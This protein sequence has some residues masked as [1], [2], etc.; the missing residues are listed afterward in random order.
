MPHQRK[1]LRHKLH[2]LDREYAVYKDESQTV[3]IFFPRGLFRKWRFKRFLKHRLEISQPII[4]ILLT[5]NQY[6]RRPE[7]TIYFVATTGGCCSE[8]CGA[9]NPESAE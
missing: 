7:G 9:E 6:Q 3:H 4:D 5:W 8:K 2:E 1:Q